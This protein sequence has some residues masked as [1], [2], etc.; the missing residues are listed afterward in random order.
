MPICYVWS[1]VSLIKCM[2]HNV[3]QKSFSHWYDKNKFYRFVLSR[4]ICRKFYFERDRKFLFW[5]I[6]TFNMLHMNCMHKPWRN[7]V[8]IVCDNVSFINHKINF[9]SIYDNKQ[10]MQITFTVLPFKHFYS[11]IMKYY[12]NYTSYISVVYNYLKIIIALLMGYSN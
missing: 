3:K 1:N 12:H 4:K 2:I 11:Y 10:N 6:T 7:D 8:A 5:S 9:H